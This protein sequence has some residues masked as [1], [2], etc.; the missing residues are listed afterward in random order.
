MNSDL[1]D[2]L[3]KKIS[4]DNIKIF[5]D[6]AVAEHRAVTIGD[7]VNDVYGIFVSDKPFETSDDEFCV[8]AHEYGHCKSGATHHLSSPL[9]MIEQHE[10]RADRAAVHEFLPFDKIKNA[11]DCGCVELWQLAEFLDMPAEFV[12]KAVD[13]YRAEGYILP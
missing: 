10:Y 11:F 7:V 6:D 1:R 8:L 4:D 5:N 9:E 2:K 12:K 3:L 13:V